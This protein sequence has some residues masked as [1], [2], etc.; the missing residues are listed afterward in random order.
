MGTD[1][2]PS[3]GGNDHDARDVFEPAFPLD[4]AAGFQAVDFAPVWVA[5]NDVAIWA[6]ACC[7]VTSS[8][9]TFQR[10]AQR[11]YNR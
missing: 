9:V 6:R 10:S 2:F 4:N 3:E 5:R 8:A 11:A 1:V 7:T